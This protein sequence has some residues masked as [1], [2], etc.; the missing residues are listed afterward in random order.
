MSR[1]KLGISSC[2]L[3]QKT[4]YDGGHKWDR[5]I[6]KTW[7]EYLE[8]VPVCPEAECGLGVPREVMRLVAQPEGP[9]LVTVYTGRDLTGRLA[10]WIESKMGHLVSENL[11]GFIFKSNSPSCGPVRVKL[12][13]EQ[14]K[15]MGQ[16]AGLFAAAFQ[17]YFPLV[18]VVDEIRLHEP[19]I[20]ENFL[21]QIFFWRRWRE[22]CAQKPKLRDLV[23]FHTRHKYQLLAHSKKYYGELGRLVAGAWGNPLPE[24]LAEYQDLASKGL[25]LRA[26]PKK[27]A[28]VLQHLL[29]Y[30]KKQLSAVEKQELLEC[31]ESYR[32]GEIPLLV[33]LTLIKHYMQRF[34]ESYLQEQFYL[35]P[36]PLEV[37]L[38][39]HV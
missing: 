37:L 14:G 20:R 19:D 29:G 28:N 7:G 10:A 15:I 38:R 22:L 27:H 26:T 25:Q 4:R 34:Q 12:Y 8:F 33:P 36:E 30:F 39:N 13:D 5:F 3:G 35:N 6:S 16:G 18:P 17:D 21:E 32:W 11:A 9:R 31:I 1:I 24:A 23:V 2:L